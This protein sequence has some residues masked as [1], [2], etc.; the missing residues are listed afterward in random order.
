[1]KVRDLVVE[2]RGSL[3]RKEDNST[4]VEEE[5][6]LYSWALVALKSRAIKE[7]PLLWGF[8]A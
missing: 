6:D 5:E 8:L 2:R 1:V 4:C 7:Y 3:Y